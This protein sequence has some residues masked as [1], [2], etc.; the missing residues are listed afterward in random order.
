MY[1]EKRWILPAML[2]LAAAAVLLVAITLALRPATTSTRT[3]ERVSD[4]TPTAASCPTTVAAAATPVTPASTTAGGNPTQINTRGF[5][6]IGMQLQNTNVNAPITN[7]HISNTASGSAT[8]A[9]NVNVGSGNTITSPTTT[10]GAGASTP[11]SSS[12]PS[13]GSAPSGSSG[14]STTGS[15]TT[16]AASA[17]GTPSVGT[18]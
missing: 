3:I 13:S 5:G 7:I 18:G 2:T 11:T 10:A 8:I 12:T 9:N 1:I 4:V 6:D 16:P 15:S 14:S 17:T